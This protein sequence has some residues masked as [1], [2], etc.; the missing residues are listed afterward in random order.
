MTRGQQFAVMEALQDEAKRKLRFIQSQPSLTG[1][2]MKAHYKEL[3]Q[4]VKT[5]KLLREQIECS[6]PTPN[7]SS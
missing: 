4:I 6:T 5:M 3:A 7:T 2:V 1:A